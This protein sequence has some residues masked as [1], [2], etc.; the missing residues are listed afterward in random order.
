MLE[1]LAAAVLR[2]RRRP[3][4]AELAHLRDQLARQRVGIPPA[5]DVRDDGLVHERPH[6][7]VDLALLVGRGRRVP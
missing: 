3:E 7:R 2:G 4:D 6:G 1:M 5:L